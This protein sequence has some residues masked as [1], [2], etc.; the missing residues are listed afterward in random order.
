M[1]NVTNFN[2]RNISGLKSDSMNERVSELL[3][4]DEEEGLKRKEKN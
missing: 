4:E 2:H 1:K 3:A